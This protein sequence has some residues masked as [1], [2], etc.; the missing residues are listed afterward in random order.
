M[1]SPLVAA[2]PVE[3]MACGSMKNRGPAL[4][5]HMT[6]HGTGHGWVAPEAQGLQGP[7]GLC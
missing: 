7:Q 5:A 3:L 6:P 1:S 4:A 2:L